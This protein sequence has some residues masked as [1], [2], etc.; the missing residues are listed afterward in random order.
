[1]KKQEMKSGKEVQYD[2]NHIYGVVKENDKNDW[3]TAILRVSWNE[4]PYTV[5]IRR[6]NLSSEIMG[7]GISLTNEEADLMV[8][9]LLQ[10]DF[11]SID[12]IERALEKRK[13]IF[14][15]VEKSV[16]K[17]DPII[18]AVFQHIV[19]FL[20][21][22]SGANGE[23][24]YEYSKFTNRK[25]G[26]IITET[27]RGCSCIDRIE[28]K[29]NLTYPIQSSGT[30]GLWHTFVGKG[31]GVGKRRRKDS[32]GTSRRRESPTFLCKDEKRE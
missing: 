26:P 7:K 6:C 23:T 18:V 11:G 25:Q 19:L 21:G 30:N 13:S 17:K 24:E 12:E 9:I 28:R 16:E 8:D 4:N 3:I 29:S 15:P 14:T 1:M 2:I 27:M 10:N 5:D 20:Y 32:Y 31:H 22:G